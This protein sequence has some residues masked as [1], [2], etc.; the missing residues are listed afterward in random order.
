M[1]KIVLE[2]RAS[3]YAQ[4]VEAR[5]RFAA[6]RGERLTDDEVMLA[7]CRAEQ[8]NAP[9]NVA[10]ATCRSCAKAF[11]RAGNREVEVSPALLARAQCDANHLGDLETDAPQRTTSTVSAAKRRKVLMRDAFTCCVPGCRSQRHLDIH[12]I[13]F[14]AHRGSNKMSNLV[15]ACAGHHRQLHEGRLTIAGTAPHALVFAFAGD[16]TDGAPLSREPIT[17]TT[18]EDLIR[19]AELALDDCERRPTEPRPLERRLAESW[20]TEFGRARPTEPRPTEP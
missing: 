8:P 13:V 20:P 18:H 19:L 4:F 15:T 10:I 12:H 5:T 2:I 16:A 17:S 6:D 14:Q 9:Y 1:V 3:T 7:L 11:Q